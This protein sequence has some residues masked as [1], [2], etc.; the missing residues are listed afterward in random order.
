M[1]KSFLMAIT[2]AA[3]MVSCTNNA[4]EIGG[5]DSLSSDASCAI[6]SYVANNFPDANIVSSKVS[7]SNVITELNTGEQVVFNTA[8]AVISYSNNASMGLKADSLGIACDSTHNDSIN[9]GHRGGKKHDDRDGKGRGKG[10]RHGDKHGN[11]STLLG[12]KHGYNRHSGSEISI[13]SLGA[14]IN[15]YISTN[16]SGYTVIHADKDTLCEGAVT[17]VMVVLS[18]AQPVKLVF[19]A[20]NAFLLKAERYEYSSVPSVVS[21]AVSAYYSAY[22]VMKKCELYTLADATLKY[23][24]HLKS[25]DSRKTVTFNADGTVSCEK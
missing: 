22:T 6:T 15:A 11:D 5:L 2:F 23:K 13:D 1:K 10:G 19:D 20:A 9:G 24:V 3:V 17:D 25:I 12:G 14:E 16:Y 7:T 8:G 21:D 18:S 4:D